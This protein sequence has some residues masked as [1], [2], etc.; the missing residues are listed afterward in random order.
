M[1]DFTVH[2][3][4]SAPSASKELLEA[5]E[6]DAGMIPNLHGVMAES[7]ELLEAYQTLHKLFLNSS[8]NNE[9]KTV[10]W[11]AVNVEHKCHYCVPGHTAIAKS[12]D[13]SD[14]IIDALRNEASLPSHEL[15][16]LR[17]FT[18]KVVRS[19]GQVTDDDLE[20]F[21]KAGYSK[22]NVLEVILAVGQKTISN[23][24]NHIAETPVDEAFEKYRWNK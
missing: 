18:L 16:A 20:D 12:M 8:F 10:V 7:P 19:R 9:Q 17:D 13:V 21:Y 3:K 11:M 22:K 24:T 2:D 1:S 15:E 4:D 23:Y 5:S 6:K 14:D